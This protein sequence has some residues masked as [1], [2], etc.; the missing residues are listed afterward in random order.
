MSCC[1]SDC[2]ATWQRDH[3]QINSFCLCC[4]FAILS[5]VSQ[6]CLTR[7]VCNWCG[8]ITKYPASVLGSTILCWRK[9]CSECVEQSK[10]SKL[11]RLTWSLCPSDSCL[12]GEHHST[13]VTHSLTNYCVTGV[14][15]CGGGSVRVCVC[16]C[17]LTFFKL[18]FLP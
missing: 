17:A 12:T 7:K 5:F 2:S 14:C 11:I 6:P 13:A 16:V 10:H 1:V 3:S 4:I 15:V 9:K 8:L 18:Q